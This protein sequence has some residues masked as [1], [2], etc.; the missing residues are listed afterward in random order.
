MYTQSNDG[1]WYMD[2]I[3]ETKGSIEEEGEI[4]PPPDLVN[5]LHLEAESLVPE[6]VQPVPK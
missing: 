5:A 2:E 6:I 1:V 3:P 4:K